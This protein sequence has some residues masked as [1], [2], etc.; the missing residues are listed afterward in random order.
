MPT[1]TNY[2][3]TTPADTDL[4]KD[5]ASAIRTLGSSIDTT[6]KAQIDAQI[7]DSLLTTTGDVIYASGASTPARL[8]I[9]TT[10]QVL[11]VSGGVP[12]WTTLSGGPGNMAQIAT[13]TFSGTSVTISSLST[14][15]ELLLVCNGYTWGTGA[16][17]FIVRVNNNSGANY[18]FFG[19]YDNAGTTSS[20]TAVTGQ[21]QFSNTYPESG[22]L[23][24][25]TDGVFT[26]KLT[27]CKTSGFTDVD[28][29][30]I[31][32]R[33]ADSKYYSQNYKGIYKVSEAVS[34]LVLTTSAG[35]TFNAG[36]YTL[37]G[38]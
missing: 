17:N 23:N 30:S 19:Y 7:P 34:S 2:G 36:T 38:A 1:T 12:A 9:G 6:L 5:G 11:S 10:G 33:N 31:F 25:N 4:V 29:K 16:A 27:N 35:Y 21:S 3:W 20:K 8:G 37:Y 28:Q 18:D 26:L 22:M 32:F 15:S 24:T 14:Y 13:G